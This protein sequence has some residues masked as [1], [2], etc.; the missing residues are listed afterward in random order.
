MRA[1][2]LKYVAASVAL[3]SGFAFLAFDASVAQASVTIGHGVHRS[4]EVTGTGGTGVIVVA[5]ILSALAVAGL[6]WAIQS[7]R[8]LV[9]AARSSSEPRQLPGARGDDKP[10]ETRKAA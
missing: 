1:H 3:L 10:D 6:A 7:D 4:G 9:V 2:L 5:L 8:H